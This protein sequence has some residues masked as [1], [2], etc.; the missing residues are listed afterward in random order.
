MMNGSLFRSS[1]A[2]QPVSPLP[3]V[4]SADLDTQL[5]EAL[6][7]AQPMEFMM[8]IFQMSSK[9]P[10]FMPTLFQ[11]QIAFFK[12]IKYPFRICIES[13]ALDRNR[14]MLL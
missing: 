9:N 7:K 3:Q 6:E 11:V 2:R 14:R 1:L 5:K 13:P 4:P 10:S 8:A 12:I